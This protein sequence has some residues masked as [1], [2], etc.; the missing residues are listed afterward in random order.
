MAPALRARLWR[1]APLAL[2]FLAG[3]RGPESAA[4]R[5]RDMALQSAYEI[6]QIEMDCPQA[7]PTITSSAAMQPKA[8]PQAFAVPQ[9]EYTVDVAGCGATRTYLIMCRE[10]GGGCA[11]TGR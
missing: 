4:E 2:L 11:P 9:L 7:T 10:D 1:T 5:F 3:C 6:G 8:D